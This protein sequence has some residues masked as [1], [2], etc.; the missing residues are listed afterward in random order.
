MMI[1]QTLNHLMK[2]RVFHAF[3]Q[4]FDSQ[5]YDKTLHDTQSAIRMQSLLHDR[6]HD[7]H[8]AISFLSALHLHLYLRS[9]ASMSISMPLLRVVVFFFAFCCSSG[10][11]SRNSNSKLVMRWKRIHAI[12]GVGTVVETAGSNDDRGT[13]SSFGRTRWPNIGH[14][15]ILRFQTLRTNRNTIAHLNLSCDSPLTTSSVL[16]NG[17]VVSIVLFDTCDQNA[18]F[19]DCGG[20]MVSFRSL[21]FFHYSFTVV[22]DCHGVRCRNQCKLCQEWIKKSIDW[23]ATDSVKVSDF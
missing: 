20:H 18:I 17:F 5:W 23:K 22:V 8:V 11:G 19:G 7:P 1:T 6:N 2:N 9:M 14:R 3:L 21:R 16:F 15:H 12:L 10:S 13:F 4:G